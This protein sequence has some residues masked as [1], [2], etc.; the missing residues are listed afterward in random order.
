MK[1]YL[2]L[3]DGH[4]FEGSTAVAFKDTISEIVF[5]TS[6]TGYPEIFTDPSYAGQAVVMT[7]P[8]IGNYGI[9]RNDLESGQIRPDFF[10]LREMARMPSNFRCEESLDHFLKKQ[11]IPVI[12]GIDTRTLTKLLREEGTMNG[13]ATTKAQ[14]NS[15][16]IRNKLHSYKTGNVVERMTCSSQYTL[17]SPKSSKMIAVLD[18]GVKRSI[19]KSL[20]RRGCSVTVFPAGTAA[21]EITGCHPDGIVLSNGPGD[22]KDCSN[23]IRE[24]KKLCDSD[25]PM[26]AVCL[27][28]QLISLAMGADTYRLKYGHRGGNHPVRN[29]LNGKVFMTSQNHGYAVKTCSM[30][31]SKAQPLF[32]NVNDGTN[33]GFLYINKKIITVQFHPEASPGPL[34]TGYLFDTF[35]KMT[36]VNQ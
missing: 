15:E 26:L 31:R 25:I 35:L 33:E 17:T 23:I 6:M 1:A 27:G 29:L 20:Q 30:D 34:D 14:E 36:E 19:L 28:H 8:M 22:P 18:F 5:N 4:V 24:I 11:D 16:I 2:M 12:T 7:Y 9:C 21:E 10:M 32:E 13:L 3:E